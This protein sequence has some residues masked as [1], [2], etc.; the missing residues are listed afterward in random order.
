MTGNFPASRTLCLLNENAQCNPIW[1]SQ[2]GGLKLAH[3]LTLQ[4]ELTGKEH[5]PVDAAYE[6]C[7]RHCMQCTHLT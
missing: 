1:L 5:V 2:P 6:T 3:Y 4:E 7:E